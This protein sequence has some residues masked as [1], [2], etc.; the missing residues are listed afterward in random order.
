MCA[1][2]HDPAAVHHKDF[3]RAGNGGQSVGNHDQRLSL[4]Q[5][6]HARLNHRLIFRIDVS[7]RLV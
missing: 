5:P 3:I 6:C 4:H 7:G 2:L 1:L